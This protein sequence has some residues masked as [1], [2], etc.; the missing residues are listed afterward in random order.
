MNGFST[1]SQASVQGGHGH[2]N[3]AMTGDEDDGQRGPER[4]QAFLQF[5]PAHVRHAH[6]EDQTAAHAVVASGKEGQGRRVGGDGVAFA[7]EEPGHGVAHGLAVIDDVNP[8]VLFMGL[9]RGQGEAEDGAAPGGVRDPQSSLVEFDRWSGRWRA[10]AH[11][12][13]LGSV[14][15]CEDRSRSSSAE[16]GPWSATAAPT[17]RPSAGVRSQR[18]ASGTGRR[19]GHGL[20]AILHQVEEHLFIMIG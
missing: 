16:A 1:K 3:V 12:V 17:L 5:Q 9:L 15:R 18:E 2:G 19:G 6:V 14:E 11:A 13:R 10:D 4:V 20:D 7:F 8:E